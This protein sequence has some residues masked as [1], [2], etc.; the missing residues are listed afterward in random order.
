MTAL[1]PP[2]VFVYACHLKI[3]AYFVFFNNDTRSNIGAF[4]EKLG[5]IS[6]FFHETQSEGHLADGLPLQ[7]HPPKRDKPS[8]TLDRVMLNSRLSTDNVFRRAQCHH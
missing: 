7:Q 6:F 2:E 1:H 4:A 5:P 3:C 8:R